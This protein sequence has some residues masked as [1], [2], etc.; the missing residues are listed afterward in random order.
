M[1]NELAKQGLGLLE[2][3]KKKDT[4]INET[5]NQLISNLEADIGKPFGEMERPFLVSLI[6]DLLRSYSEEREFSKQITEK[7]ILFSEET[8]VDLRRVATKMV[9]A[10]RLAYKKRIE[11]RPDQ[12]D[13]RAFQKAVKI[14]MEVYPT[15]AAAVR[16]LRGKPEF[17]DYP[18]KTLREW[19]K[20]VWDKPTKR[21]APKKT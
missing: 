5:A 4:L 13:K 7:L 11:D 9:V 20:P 21:G 19:L 3:K 2:I 1:G 15:K 14:N 10:R 6:V 18:D 12:I 16:D 8:M 17:E